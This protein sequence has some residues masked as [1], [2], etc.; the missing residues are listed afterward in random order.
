M[1]LDGA[2]WI[3]ITQLVI[4]W[5][6]V[7]PISSVCNKLSLSFLAVICRHPAYFHPLSSLCAVW[8]AAALFSLCEQKPT[9]PVPEWERLHMIVIHCLWRFISAISCAHH[10]RLDI[11]SGTGIMLNLTE[12]YSYCQ[13]A[14]EALMRIIRSPAVCSL[15]RFTYS[16]WGKKKRVFAHCSAHL[17]GSCINL[18]QTGVW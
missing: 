18:L 13:I 16:C 15:H 1:F 3:H 11:S 2:A 9:A 7:H 5:K 10:M 12:I 14:V 4:K 8:V 6:S 17:P